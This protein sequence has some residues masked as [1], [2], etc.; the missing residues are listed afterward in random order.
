MAIG[1]F[2]EWIMHGASHNYESQKRWK[3]SRRKTRTANENKSLR[4]LE[5]NHSGAKQS[6][7]FMLF[8][9]QKMFLFTTLSVQ[10]S[11][12]IFVRCGRPALLLKCFF[13]C[14]HEFIDFYAIVSGSSGIYVSELNWISL[15]IEKKR[16]K[17]SLFTITAELFDFIFIAHMDENEL[18]QLRSCKAEQFTDKTFAWSCRA[19]S[20]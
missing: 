14:I 9:K 11:G 17:K 20:N 15:F 7:S 2:V 4:D 16:E 19:T 6:R 3:A 12:N 18:K 1:L 8:E 5:I 10:L 13:F